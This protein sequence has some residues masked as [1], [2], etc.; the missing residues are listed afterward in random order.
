MPPFMVL[1]HFYEIY[2]A[3]TIIKREEDIACKRL[4]QGSFENMGW[5]PGSVL[6]IMLRPHTGVGE[7]TEPVSA[8]PAL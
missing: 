3:F 4:D 8:S 7:Q 2:L 1:E 5:A 6:F